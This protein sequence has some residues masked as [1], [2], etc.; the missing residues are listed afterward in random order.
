MAE[1]A[2]LEKMVREFWEAVLNQGDTSSVA[3]VLSPAYTFNGQAQSPDG[4]AGWVTAL[5]QQFAPLH[6]TIDDLLG[7]GDKIAIR[8]T[9]E[10]TE[11]GHAVTTS[12]TNIITFDATPQAVSNWQNGGTTFSPVKG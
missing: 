11:K 3:T 7:Q 10:A 1:V 2:T 9:L 4:V 12:G 6:F 5:H 8:W